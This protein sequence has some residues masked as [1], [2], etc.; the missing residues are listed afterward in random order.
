MCS[1]R[2]LV[3]K[4]N[5][6]ATAAAALLVCGSWRVDLLAADLSS[7]EPQLFRLQLVISQEGLKRLREE[8]RGYVRAELREG[9]A[10]FENVAIHL[11]G[12]VGS[13]RSIDAKPA[14]T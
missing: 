7:D 13:F 12:S 11:K 3:W 14:F 5:V 6:K 8:P 1:G 10:R 2:G 4:M 9:A